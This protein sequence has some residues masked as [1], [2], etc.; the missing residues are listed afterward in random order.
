MRDAVTQKHDPNEEYVVMS[1]QI[2]N[3]FEE[4]VSIKDWERCKNANDFI[5]LLISLT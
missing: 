1:W 5:L 2:F 3:P 4:F